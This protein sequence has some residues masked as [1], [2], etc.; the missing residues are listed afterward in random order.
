MTADEELK[1]IETQASLR[2]VIIMMEASNSGSNIRVRESNHA[3]L[4][5]RSCYAEG[6]AYGKASWQASE[7]WFR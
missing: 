4:E 7:Q 3:L 6:R 2:D 5:R 1:L